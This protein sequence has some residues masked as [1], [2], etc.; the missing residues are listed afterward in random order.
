MLAILDWLQDLPLIALVTGLL[1]GIPA[2]FIRRIRGVSA[3]IVGC[4]SWV[5]LFTLWIWCIQTLLDLW[6]IVP[7][8]VGLVMG[9]IGIIP[10]SAILFLCTGH[11]IEFATVIIM[12]I[13]FGVG[14]F[15]TVR[16]QESVARDALY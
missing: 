4:C 6:G 8:I 5:I 3:G 15:A 7:V 11:W 14:R 9:L 10:L 12:M 1:V 2:I 16:F 13:A